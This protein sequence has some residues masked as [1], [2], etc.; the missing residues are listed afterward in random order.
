[1]STWQ[2]QFTAHLPRLGHRNWIVVT[3]AAYPEQSA[4]G[5]NVVIADAPIDEV[6]RF[7]LTKLHNYGHVTPK[8]LLDRELGFLTDD[9]CPGVAA[10]RSSIRFETGQLPTT[11]SLHEMVLEKLNMEAANYS[12]FVIKTNTMIPYTSVFL[13]LECGYWDNDREKLLRELL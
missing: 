8:V 5:V 10:L 4:P 13:Q 9:L 7:V 3:D 11:E 1:M 6:L 2:S 12:V